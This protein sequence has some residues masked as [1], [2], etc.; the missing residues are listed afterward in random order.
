MIVPVSAVWT[1]PVRFTIRQTRRPQAPVTHG[2]PV[3]S[4]RSVLVVLTGAAAFAVAD[5][6]ACRPR[7]MGTP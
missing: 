6:L 3:A 5:G 1:N 7:D 2:E 4:A